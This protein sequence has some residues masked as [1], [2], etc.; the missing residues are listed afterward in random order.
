MERTDATVVVME[1][2]CVSCKVRTEG[3]KWNELMQTERLVIPA[4]FFPGIVFV[5]QETA[6]VMFLFP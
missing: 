5:F 4:V 3:I 2:Q 1:T 6:A